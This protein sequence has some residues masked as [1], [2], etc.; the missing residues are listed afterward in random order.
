[1]Q[2][3]IASHKQVITTASF[4]KSFSFF[5]VGYVAYLALSYVA[6]NHSAVAPRPCLFV[7]ELLTLLIVNLFYVSTLLAMSAIKKGIKLRMIYNVCK[8][9]GPEILDHLIQ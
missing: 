3:V 1:M 2:H 9:W 5:I 6:S 4:C 8:Q 7:P